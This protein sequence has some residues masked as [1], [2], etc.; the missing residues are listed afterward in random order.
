VQREHD[1]STFVV[2]RDESEC[3]IH[4]LETEEIAQSQA[5]LVVGR[6]KPK[7]AVVYSPSWE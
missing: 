1:K 2:R 3:E 7:L 5:G 4:Y 6:S